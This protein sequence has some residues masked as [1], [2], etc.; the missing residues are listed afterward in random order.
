VII[1]AID[2]R[3]Q[4]VRFRAAR[5]VVYADDGVTPLSLAVAVAS[6]PPE[7]V[8]TSDL[9]QAEFPRILRGLGI[10]RTVVVTR[11]PGPRLDD[12]PRLSRA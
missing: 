5:V 11:A 2:H 1:E 8:I 4:P 6:G 3:G 7:Q 12:F 9:H 10:D